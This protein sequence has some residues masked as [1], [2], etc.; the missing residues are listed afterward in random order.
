MMA[1]YD[2]DITF[3]ENGTTGVTLP[4]SIDTCGGYP[5]NCYQFTTDD[6]I[7]IRMD[8]AVSE[9]LLDL[10]NQTVNLITHAKGK[11]YYG[12]L[13]DA[14]SSSGWSI[15]EGDPDSL[16]VTVGNNPAKLLSKLMNGSMEVYIGRITGNL[17][18]LC[19]IPAS[20]SPEIA[21]DHLW[22]Y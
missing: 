19:F 20:E 11:A 14:K 10:K 17:G 6:N 4:L 7:Y 12:L 3:I 2:R 21:I 8:D 18:N 13:T 16:S 15:T 22:D 5:I 1:E 9:H